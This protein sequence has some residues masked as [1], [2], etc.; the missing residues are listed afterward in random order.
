MAGRA[1]G[2]ACGLG[3]KAGIARHVLGGGG[4]FGDGGGDQFDITELL[5]YPVVGAHGDIGGIFR[6]IGHLLHRADHFADHALQF[7]EKGVEAP[8]NITELIGTVFRQTTC[9]ITF[10]L[11]DIVEHIGQLPG[12]TGQA[13]ANQ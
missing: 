10:A 7:V 6:R 8:G 12:R 11:G 2:V 4:H 3:G 13:V 5:L 9:Q 1:V